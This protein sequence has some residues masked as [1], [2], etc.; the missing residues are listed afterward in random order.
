MPECRL[1]A[2]ALP[3]ATT[4]KACPALSAAF[5][6]LSKYER[7][8]PPRS[9]KNSQ[10]SKMR[11]VEVKVIDSLPHPE[12]TTEARHCPEWPARIGIVNDYVRIP[13]AN[14]SSFASQFLYREFRKRGH[15]VTIIGA[16]DPETMPADLPEHAVSFFS[17]PLRNHPG[18]HLALPSRTRLT[19]LEHENLDVVLAQTGSAMLEAGVWLRARR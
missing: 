17:L 19:Q 9:E 13:Y 6:S 12:V 18:V 8:P 1:T 5:P 2:C 15:R 7:T 10:R 16:D 11:S 3:G 14:G 4:V